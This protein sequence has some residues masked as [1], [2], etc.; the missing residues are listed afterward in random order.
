VELG[1][2]SETTPTLM[3]AGTTPSWPTLQLLAEVNKEIL[4]KNQLIVKFFDQNSSRKDI[5]LGQG[6]LSVRPFCE[7]IDQSVRASAPITGSNGAV[8]GELELNAVLSKGDPTQFLEA[9]P[10]SAVVVE[11]GLLKIIKM[12]AFDLGGGDKS[13]FDSKPVS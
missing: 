11:K 7:R 5:P 3:N 13:I 10:E 9:L 8:T 1:E 12:A 4:E 2:W 6:T